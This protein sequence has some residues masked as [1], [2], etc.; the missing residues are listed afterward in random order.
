MHDVPALKNHE[1]FSKSGISGLYSPEQY[2][3]IWNDYQKYLTL[4]LTLL[5]NGTENEL[6]TPYQILLKTAK[7]TTEQHVFHYASQA[8][9][10][11]FVMEQYADKE[12]AQKTKPLRLLLEK[13][14]TLDIPD[15]NTLREKMLL[16]ADSSF[17]QGWVFLVEDAN[18]NLQIIRCNNDGTPYYYGKN[19]ALDMNGGV[20]EASF[21]YLNQ[22]KSMATSKTK[23]W[24][25]PIL[26]INCWDVAYLKDYGVNGKADY[27][28]NMW[29]CINWDVVNKRIFQV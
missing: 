3:T 14:A 1:A 15:I 10:N 16:L 21:E 12:T 7:Q 4:Q 6:R 11:H 13:L 27:L 29:D 22:L 24:T 20:D 19:Q 9:N 2:K 18:K 26:G 28:A 25:L 23:D 5:T 8:H 17:G